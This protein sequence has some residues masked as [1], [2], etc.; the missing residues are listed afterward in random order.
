MTARWTTRLP[1]APTSPREARRWVAQRLA[2]AGYGDPETAVLIVSELVTNVVQHGG[3][4]TVRVAVRV[5]PGEWAQLEVRDDM[6]VP[7]Q[8]LA[9]PSAA[10]PADSEHGRGLLLVSELSAA[11]GT[12]GRGMAWARL[13]WIAAAPAVDDGALFPLPAAGGAR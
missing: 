6:A 10:P 9:F 5:A 12:D 7:G 8:P 1:S 4:G 3:G 13:P 2:E 11:S